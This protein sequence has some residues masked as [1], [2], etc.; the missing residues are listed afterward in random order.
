M[1]VLSL[2]ILII[3][4]TV[5][6]TLRG[7][8]EYKMFEVINQRTYNLYFDVFYYFVLITNVCNYSILKTTTWLII[9]YPNHS[10]N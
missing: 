8:R 5:F 1:Y 4:F 10:I 6:V 7:R 2:I 9:K 3:K